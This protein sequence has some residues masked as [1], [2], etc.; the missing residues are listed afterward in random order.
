L[1]GV[2]QHFGRIEDQL[3]NGQMFRDARRTRLPA[4][5]VAAVGI[6]SRRSVVCGIGGGRFFWRAEEFEL[7]GITMREASKLKRELEERMKEVGSTLNPERTQVVYVDTFD[8]WNVKIE[9]TFLGY[10]FKLRTLKS[11]QT[12]KLARKCLELRRKR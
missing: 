7:G 1:A 2:G 11:P 3:D 6:L 8:R 12:G 10:D 9:V 4:A 5:L